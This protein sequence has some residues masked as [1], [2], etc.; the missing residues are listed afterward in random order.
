MVSTVAKNSVNLSSHE[1]CDYM[2][3]D[4]ITKTLYLLYIMIK[5]RNIV[6]TFVLATIFCG[7]SCHTW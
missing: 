5:A 1:A 6:F 3:A 2:H 7:V 4:S